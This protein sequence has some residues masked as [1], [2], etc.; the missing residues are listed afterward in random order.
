MNADVNPEQR[1]EVCFE[2]L[3]VSAGISGA[4]AV[5]K[6]DVEVAVR[7]EF[8]VAAVVVIERLVDFEDDS[9]ASAKGAV[10]IFFLRQFS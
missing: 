9:F 8:D 2:V 6:G 3:A 4:S 7:S 5:A 10:G 1:T